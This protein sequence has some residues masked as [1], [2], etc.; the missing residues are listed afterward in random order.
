MGAPN[1]IYTF[2]N[3]FFLL[4]FLEDRLKNEA[5]RSLKDVIQGTFSY[6][7]TLLWKELSLVEANSTQGQTEE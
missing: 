2:I 3:V 7:L 6:V 4:S 1:D 5:S